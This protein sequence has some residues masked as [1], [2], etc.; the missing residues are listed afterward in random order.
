MKIKSI[1]LHNILQTKS[2]GAKDKFILPFICYTSTQQHMNHIPLLRP[3][4]HR[5]NE[6]KIFNKQLIITSKE[7][8]H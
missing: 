2:V 1:E 5:K 3:E 8:G 7:K 6:M 4:P